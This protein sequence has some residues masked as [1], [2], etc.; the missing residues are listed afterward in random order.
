VA[1]FIVTTLLIKEQLH[2]FPE[3]VKVPTLFPFNVKVCGIPDPL[4][5]TPIP[6]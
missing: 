4:Q 2:Q 1:G 6:T 3:G 5:S